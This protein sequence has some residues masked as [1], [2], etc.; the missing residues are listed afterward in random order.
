MRSLRQFCIPIG[1]IYCKVTQK[2]DYN[3]ITNLE[4]AKRCYNNCIYF[5]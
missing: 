3:Q 1:Y 4:N 2:N 5:N